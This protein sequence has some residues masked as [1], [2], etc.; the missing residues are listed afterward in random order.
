[1]D[2]E[3]HVHEKGRQDAA[4]PVRSQ[5]TGGCQP[6]MQVRESQMRPKR[7]ARQE[8]KKGGG[9]YMISMVTSSSAFW[10]IFSTSI[11]L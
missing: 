3:R 1:M 5:K 2:R 7:R 11:G 8:R 9:G 6:P 10:S 4:L